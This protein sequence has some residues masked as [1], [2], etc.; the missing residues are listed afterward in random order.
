MLWR[1]GY[2][3][4][5]KTLYTGSIPVGTSNCAKGAI[6]YFSL[7]FLFCSCYN[8]IMDNNSIASNKKL[9]PVIII[10]CVA[11][12][13]L[14]LIFFAPTLLRIFRDSRRKA[15]YKTL[16]E[17]I[18]EVYMENNMGSLPNETSSF[19]ASIY[20]NESGKDLSGNDYV[21]SPVFCLGEEDCSE[22]KISE[23]SLVYDSDGRPAAVTYVVAHAVCS[24]GR[25]S[26]SESNTS[27]AVYGYLESG[28]YCYA[29][30]N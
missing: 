14:I 10:S 16:S 7:T 23:P 8:V 2:A 13:C 27:Y 15:D 11:V 28:S 18:S 22:S 26:Y 19:D 6:F 5:C 21:I 1:S 17:N 20:I 30:E 29:N 9:K 24:D 25:P 12:V 4:V 3:E